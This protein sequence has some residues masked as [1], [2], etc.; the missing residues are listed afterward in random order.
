MRAGRDRR[1]SRCIVLQRFGSF[2][3]VSCLRLG[4]AVGHGILRDVGEMGYLEE[5]GEVV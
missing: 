5:V 1:L 4:L 3:V 2:W